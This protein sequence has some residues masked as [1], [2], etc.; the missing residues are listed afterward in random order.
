MTYV[1]RWAWRS[2][3]PAVWSWRV[4]RGTDGPTPWRGRYSSREAARAAA[5][6]AQR[7]D[8]DLSRLPIVDTGPSEV[9]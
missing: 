2:G 3:R 6:E 9:R 1:V 7:A 8:A 5:D 4:W